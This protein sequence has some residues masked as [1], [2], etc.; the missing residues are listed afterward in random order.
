MK[1]IETNR[2]ILRDYIA[3][4]AESYFKLKSDQKTMYY[5]QDIQLFSREEAT[6][7]FQKVLLDL[8]SNAREFYFFHMELKSTSEQVG[9]IGYTVE[10]N[11]PVG[12]RVGVGYFIY[13]KFWGKGYTTEALKK[14]L[15]FGFIEN[16]V[17]R[18]TTGCLAEN[19]GSEKV[20]KKC[21]FIKEAELIEYEWHDGKLKNRVLYRLLKNEWE[22]LV[23][24]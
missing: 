23:R 11:T 3:T 2:L 7:D 14:V 24:S 5:L 4:D 22:N 6:A 12:K 16:N 10:E 1:Y 20:M 17:Y 15:E 13:P 9:S 19:M 8:K 18:F 21:G